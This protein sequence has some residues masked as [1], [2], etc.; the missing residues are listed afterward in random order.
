[1]HIGSLLPVS[2][3]T[4]NVAHTSSGIIGSIITL[5]FSVPPLV[6]AFVVSDVGVVTDFTGF[7]GLLIAL[8]LIP[9]LDLHSRKQLLQVRWCFV[10]L[11]VP[12]CLVRCMH[13]CNVLIYC[14]P[15]CLY[16]LLH[17]KI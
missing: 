11:Y 9:C 10:C 6:G 13:S 15:A 17:V 4:W 8:C 12:A 2:I 5:F 7:I 1:M 3:P 14:V 16:L